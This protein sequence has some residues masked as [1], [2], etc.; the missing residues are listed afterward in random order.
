MT[1][2]KKLSSPQLVAVQDLRIGM[3]VVAIGQQRQ[4]NEIKRSGRITQHRQLEELMNLGVL[5]VWIDPS[6]TLAAADSPNHAS[7]DTAIDTP[8]PERDNRPRQEIRIRRLYQEA[9]TMQNKLF[10]NLKRGEPVQVDE[11]EAI[12]DELVDSIFENRDALFCLA[13]IRE[14]DSYLMEHS[15][16]VGMLLANFGRFLELERPV[17]RELTIGG[18][19]HDTGKIMIPDHILHKPGRLTED[20][21]IIMKSHVNHSISILK[22]SKGITPVM[23]TVAAC[24]H[25]RLDGKG[26]PHGLEGERLNLYARMST[27]VDVYDA[28]TADRCYKAGMPATAAF[29]ILLQGAGSQFDEELVRKFI[30]C[31]GIHPVGT[32][33][34]LQSGK[35]AIVVE[36]NEQAP[37]QPKVKVIYSTIGQHHLEVKLLDLARPGVNETIEGVVDPKSFGI[38]MSRYLA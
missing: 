12:A 29:R 18:L 25:E 32:L 2:E 13:R 34:K 33:V 1:E 19:L 31:M 24:H 8:Q 27:I 26:Y 28:L 20:E 11:L 21:F 4:Q 7:P 14:K 37:L 6:K 23:M 35:L 10:H 16:N 9:K 22:E 5:S 17:L 3:Y 30:K 38:D 36:R 15:L